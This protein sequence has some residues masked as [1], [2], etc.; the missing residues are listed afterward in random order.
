MW[1]FIPAKEAK[2]K[3]RSLKGAVSVS[4]AAVDLAA[5]IYFNLDEKAALLIGA[6][7]TGELTAKHLVARGINKLFITNRTLQKAE[8]LASRLD[9]VAIPF[10]DL[11]RQMLKTDI[12]ISSI[13]SPGY[14]LTRQDVTSI[15]QKRKHSPLLII[16]IGVPRNIDPE[17]NTIGNIFLHDMDSLSSIVE[18]SLHNRSKCIPEVNNIVSEELDEFER[19]CRSHSVVPLVDE[20]QSIYE[21]IRNEELNYHIHKF[22]NED[23]DLID[24]LTKRIVH[25]LIQLPANE[26][27]NGVNESQQQKELKI[28]LVRKLFGLNGRTSESAKQK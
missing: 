14:V 26:L 19:W 2:P 18:Q 10:E 22:R 28:S 8:D 13:N 23:R 25:R 12:V 15:L 20:L 3:P 17:I 27:R 5:K 24:H 11:H 7:E 21:N 4:Y 16:D 9:A 1:P 6:G